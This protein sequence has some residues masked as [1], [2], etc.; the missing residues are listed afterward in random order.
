VVSSQNNPVN[1][2]IYVVDKDLGC[3]ILS[4]NEEHNENP[5]LVDPCVSPVEEV[6]GIWK[7]FFD[8]A[9]S[10][11]VWAGIIL[12][13]P[14]KKEIHLSYKLEFEAKNNV[15][16]YEALILGL[17]AA[18]KMQITMLVVFGDSELFVKKVKGSYR[19][20]HLRMR[21]YRNK[22]WDMIKNFYVAFNI[23]IF[24]LRE[25]N[26]PTYSLEVAS[27]TFKL[28]TTPQ[29][30]YEIKMRYKPSIPDNIKW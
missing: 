8:Y 17:E 4:I 1:H 19:T 5:M 2:P 16:E 26:Q 12:I 22:V 11:G 13:S 29:F 25:F 7:M 24:I 10:K 23:F 27:S 28:P 20:S 9:S 21:A 6:D 30:K 14:T 18:R 15:V 3:F